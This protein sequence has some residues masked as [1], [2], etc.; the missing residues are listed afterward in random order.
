MRSKEEYVYGHDRF[1]LN[2]TRR[3]GWGSFRW[4]MGTVAVSSVKRGHCCDM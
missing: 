1:T 3:N 4:E 2:F